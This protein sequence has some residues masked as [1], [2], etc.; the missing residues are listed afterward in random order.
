MFG[1]GNYIIPWGTDLFNGIDGSLNIQWNQGLTDL[2]ARRNMWMT[3]SSPSI[4]SAYPSTVQAIT[5]DSLILPPMNMSNFMGG[6][7]GYGMSN[8]FSEVSSYVGASS[9]NGADGSSQTNP[10]N[11][12]WSYNPW[13]SMNP[14]SNPYN[15]NNSNNSTTANTP[16]E[17]AYQRKY[18]KMDTF[19]KALNDYANLDDVNIL[20]SA[21]KE[22]YQEM[23]TSTRGKSYEEKFKAAEEFYK[24]LP[25]ATIK[26]FLLEGSMKL[27][28]NGKTA[29]DGKSLYDELESI[30]YENKNGDLESNPNGNLI[31][32]L[33]EK[34]SKLGKEDA[35]LE[36]AM[37]NL[38]AYSALDVIS[39][40]NSA[41]AKNDK[42]G[43]AE[44]FVKSY[45]KVSPEQQDTVKAGMNKLVQSLIVQARSIGDKSDDDTKT[46]IYDAADKLDKSFE[47]MKNTGNFVRDFN[48]L[49]VL[50]RLAGVR[51]LA[52]KLADTYSSVDSNLFNKN[53]F[54]DDT[55]KDLKEE[56][57]DS[58]ISKVESKVT[59]P[60]SAV[61]NPSNESDDDSVQEA[62]D[63]EEDTISK[64]DSENA[65]TLGEKMAK[66][67]HGYTDN[68][69]YTRV[70]SILSDINSA[71]VMPFLDGYYEESGNDGIIETLDTEHDGGAILMENKKNLINALLAK[72]E[73][74]GIDGNKN[75]NY[76]LLEDM[77]NKYED[78]EKDTFNHGKF[79]NWGIAAGAPATGVAVY[80][81]KKFI[82]SNKGS[83]LGNF[84]K[85][86]LPAIGNVAKKLIKGKGKIALIGGLLLGLST[87]GSCIFK[88]KDN[89]KIDK[90]M[91]ALYKDIKSTSK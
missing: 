54:Y 22:A 72:A 89:E 75:D 83:K 36:E 68:S 24:S 56:G 45:K 63:E 26:K 27:S 44:K 9:S 74:C 43:I 13:Q 66:T 10:N 52:N 6:Y 87:L 32:K 85:K 62:S 67:L 17:R 60:E 30:G 8:P 47:T 78:N 12:M 39:S 84:I 37:P 3:Q 18:E 31:T 76:A 50:A 65:K 41:Y 11:G 58:T 23:L 7:N 19:L 80:G 29:T 28:T 70:N 79:W 38:G 4:F 34:L 73:E 25:E 21:Q 46:A 20:T 49:Y 40:Y 57:L 82:K 59:A 1:N 35:N 14:W 42:A 55:I 77:L 86:K 51:V 69:Y 90:A 33:H 2:A 81:A 53:M 16:E 15:N 61:T 91:K 71:T 5:G 64:E 48:N 88:N